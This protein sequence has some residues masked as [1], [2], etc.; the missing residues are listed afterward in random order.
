MARTTNE[1][2]ATMDDEQ[3]ANTELNQLNNP[4]QTAIF[5]LW[6]YI[7]AQSTRV[8]EVLIDRKKAEIEQLLS[9]NV[10]PSLAWIREKTFEFQYDATTPQVLKL[11]DFTPKYDPVDVT[12]RIITRCTVIS[13]GP[14]SIA[15]NVAKNEPPVKLTPTEL[16]SVRNYWLSTGN[17]TTKAVGL[18]FAGQGITFTSL[19]PDLLFLKANIRYIGANAS[20]IQS[21]CLAAIRAYISNLGITGKFRIIDMI[22]QL[23]AV[24]GFVSMS[25][26]DLTGRPATVSFPATGV[27]YEVV[28]GYESQV[29]GGIEINSYTPLAGYMISET[30]ASN[31][32][33]DTITFTPI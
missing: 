6:K 1:I 3:A 29:Y 19:D 7:V 23:Q 33:E 5:R 26:E 2:I 18:G 14:G 25:I 4:S 22:D 15:I 31:T 9:N 8:L 20:T 16:T 10:V 28:I 12:K 30:T 13:P 24:T 11:V 21:E 27:P 32:F 17:G